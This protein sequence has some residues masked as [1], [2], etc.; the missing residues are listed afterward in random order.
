MEVARVEIRCDPR[1]MASRA[2]PA[3]LGFAEEGVLRRRL[4]WADGTFRDCASFC[5]TVDDYP[6]TPC[7]TV[8]L[9][10]FDALGRRLV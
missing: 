2:I 3:K 7:A 1:N 5:L 6:H 8:E 9:A 10:A 4:P